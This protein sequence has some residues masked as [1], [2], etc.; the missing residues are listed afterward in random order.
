MD[1]KFEM[2]MLAI[3]HPG[4]GYIDH[5]WLEKNKDGTYKTDFVRTFYDGWVMGLCL[6][7]L[8]CDEIAGDSRGRGNEFRRGAGE[9]SSKIR[10]ILEQHKAVAMLDVKPLEQKRVNGVQS[11]ID[12]A[13]K[14]CEVTNNI[15]TIEGSVLSDDIVKRVALDANLTHIILGEAAM[16][17]FSKSLLGEMQ[18]ERRGSYKATGIFGQYLRV[19]FV[20]AP[21]VAMRNKIMFIDVNE[22]KVIASMKV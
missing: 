5:H 17:S 18:L 19:V 21:F 3:N 10:Y 14:Y 6:A 11:A 2:M 1:N 8:Q 22:G 16:G 12:I 7:Q 4:I 13:G 20:R 9:A 15:P